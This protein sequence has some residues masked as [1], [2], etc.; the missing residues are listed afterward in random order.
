MVPT[1][2]ENSNFFVYLFVN[3][4]LLAM[5]GEPTHTTYEKVLRVPAIS[6]IVKYLLSAMFNPLHRIS[7]QELCISAIHAYRKKEIVPHTSAISIIVWKVKY[8][9][10][11]VV[12]YV[13]P[14]TQQYLL[15]LLNAIQSLWIQGVKNESRTV[16]KAPLQLKSVATIKN[17][18]DF[19]YDEKPSH[20]TT[21]STLFAISKVVMGDTRIFRTIRW[22]VDIDTFQ[23][24]IV[25]LICMGKL[26]VF[27]LYGYT[28]WG[29]FC[30][31]TQSK[32]FES[33][34]R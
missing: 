23:Y 20:V 22:L 28:Q 27:L 31:H 7:N 30:P 9:L 12:G 15:L 10:H 5:T 3:F 11:F 21:K 13:Q 17:T 6:I 33:C 14:V 8:P 26:L 1:L 4:F 18:D 25:T 19:R 32:W 24:Y 2:V 34:W 16:R 29:F